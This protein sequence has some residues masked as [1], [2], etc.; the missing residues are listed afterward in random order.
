MGDHLNTVAFEVVDQ[1]DLMRLRNPIWQN[2]PL[3]PLLVS[4]TSQ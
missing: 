2:G 3:L 1:L 4:K